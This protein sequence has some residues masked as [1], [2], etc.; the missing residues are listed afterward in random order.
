MTRRREG[1]HITAEK[2]AEKLLQKAEKRFV[3]SFIL[4]YKSINK[5][6]KK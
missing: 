5:L 3:E 2:K 1:N 4:L 6:I